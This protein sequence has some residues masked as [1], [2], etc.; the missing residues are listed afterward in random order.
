MEGDDPWHLPVGLFPST[1]AL[2]VGNDWDFFGGQGLR[3]ARALNSF[4]NSA[5]TD[6]STSFF[7]AVTPA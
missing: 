1:G 3:T 6:A 7:A 5:V 2:L 4:V